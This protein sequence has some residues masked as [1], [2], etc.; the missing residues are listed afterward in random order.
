MN[1]QIFTEVI[2]LIYFD[3]HKKT[4]VEPEFNVNNRKPLVQIYSKQHCLLYK[5]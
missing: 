2:I 4:H 3:P 1:Q 5:T